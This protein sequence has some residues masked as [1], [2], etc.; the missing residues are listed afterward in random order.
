MTL[1]VITKLY[2]NY[3]RKLDRKLFLLSYKVL[4]QHIVFMCKYIPLT[5]VYA[6][7]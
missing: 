6:I 2:S 5:I 4:V 1:E 7:R 3:S